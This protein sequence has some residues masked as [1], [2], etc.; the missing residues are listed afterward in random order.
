MLLAS[1]GTDSSRNIPHILAVWGGAFRGL[2]VEVIS[3]AAHEAFMRSSGAFG[4]VRGERLP[5]PDFGAHEQVAQM[6]ADELIELGWHAAATVSVG[7][8]ERE[9]LSA[10]KSWKADLIVTGSR[11]LGTLRRLLLGSVSHN[12]LMHSHSSLLVMRGNVPARLREPAFVGREAL[13]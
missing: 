10:A 11:G 1:D 7:D 2:P 12:L 5:H 4:A 9:I 13:A 8:P 6:V 3:V